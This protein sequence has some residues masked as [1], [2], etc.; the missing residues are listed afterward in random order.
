MLAW[1]AVYILSEGGGSLSPC[2]ALFLALLVSARAALGWFQNRLQ[3]KAAACTRRTIR[4]LE[5]RLAYKDELILKL[6]RV[7]SEQR[8]APKVHRGQNYFDGG[9]EEV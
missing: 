1:Y 4:D 6:G 5:E 9:G 3:S 8:T 2:S 7:L